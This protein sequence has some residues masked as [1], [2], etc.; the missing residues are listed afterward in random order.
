MAI[1]NRYIP[2]QMEA[3]DAFHEAFMKVFNHISQYQ[4]GSLEGWMRRI[5]VN[6]CIN[7]YHK[8]KNRHLIEDINE[9]EYL[10][11]DF[12]D[13]FSQMSA[14][15][16]HKLINELPT[17]ARVV[18]NLFVIE[19]YAHKEIAEMLKLSEGTTKSQLNRAKELLR[20][21]ILVTT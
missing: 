20:E 2:Q 9:K 1:C 13:V 10:V 6:T 17:G 14:D 21:K 5:F 12:P 15:H 8:G 16:I 11:A 3:E 18:F 19:G 7:Y 4:G